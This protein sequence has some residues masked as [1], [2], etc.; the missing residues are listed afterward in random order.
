[1]T[2]DQIRQWAT[3]IWGAALWT[4]LQIQRLKRFATRAV[5]LEREGC[6]TVAESYEPRCDTCPSGVVNAI[7]GRGRA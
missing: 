4:D 5:E 3:D 7:R 6:A 1:M 2:D